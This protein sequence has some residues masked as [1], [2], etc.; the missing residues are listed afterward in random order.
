MWDSLSYAGHNLFN[1]Y[2]YSTAEEQRKNDFAVDVRDIDLHY[3]YQKVMNEPSKE[4]QEALKNEISHRIQID[5]LFKDAAGVILEDI[6][7]EKLDTLPKDFD[8]Y[9]DLI[10]NFEKSCGQADTYTLKYFKVFAAQ[11]H[12]VEH[13]P[14]AAQG[15]KTQMTAA[16]EKAGMVP[17]TIIE[18]Q[19]VEQ[20]EEFTQ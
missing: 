11:C 5:D 13:Y 17:P 6:K 15:F 16:C 2:S 7:N 3:L 9:R 10:D 8:C 1:T 4:N 12:A 20:L 14:P 19:E 18:E